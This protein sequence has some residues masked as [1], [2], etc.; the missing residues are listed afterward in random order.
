MELFENFK[1]YNFDNNKNYA[2]NNFFE[3]IKTFGFYIRSNKF[4]GL[5]KWNL[6]K[7]EC[8]DSL[9][10]KINLN[11]YYWDINWKLNDNL[12]DKIS[13]LNLIYLHFLT[14]L[15]ISDENDKEED[16]W[17]QKHFFLQL[18]RIIKNNKINFIRIMQIAYNIGQLEAEYEWYDQNVKNIYKI[19]HLNIMS[20][21]VSNNL[22]N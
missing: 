6:L 20:S 9:A 8:L 1:T 7:H 10:K 15:Q 13:D 5:E 21:Y 17:E 14:L 16:N 4:D 3:K 12:D 18:I 11:D 19:N 22:I 2:L